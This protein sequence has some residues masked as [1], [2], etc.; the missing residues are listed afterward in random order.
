M[1]DKERL[2]VLIANRGLAE[3]RERAKAYIMAGVV[4]VNGQKEDK[5]GLKVDVTAQIEVREKMRYVS[6]G[7]FKLEKAMA[8]F[9]ITL[10]DKICMDVGASTGGFTDC[11]LQ[12][13]AQKVYSIDVGYGQ[14]AWKLREDPRVVCMEKTN[15]RYVTHEEVPDEID[16]SSID[17]SF[18]SLTKILLPVYNL[19]KDGGEVGALIKPQFEAGREQVEKHGVVKDP[20]VHKQVIIKVW[21]Y[22]LSIG[23]SVHGLDFSPIKGPEGN[24]EYLI[25]LRKDAQAESSL[26]MEG[27][28]EQVVKASHDSL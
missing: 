16:F 12:N 26:D 27:L 10:T 13:G 9:P 4:Y 17:V 19:L 18:I 8:Q 2:D 24:I 11:M 6:R 3:S 23:F 7:G 25:Y 5:A 22:A 1:A 21:E 28:A 15:M 20:K 14:L